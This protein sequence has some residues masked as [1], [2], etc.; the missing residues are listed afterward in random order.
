MLLSILWVSQTTTC[1][2]TPAFTH[3]VSLAPVLT[4]EWVIQNDELWIHLSKSTPGWAAIAWAQDMSNGDVLEIQKLPDDTSQ[5]NVTNCY[6]VGHKHPACTMTQQYTT[7]SFSS[8]DSNFSVIVK[9][10]L[11]AT[12]PTHGVS[13]QPGSNSLVWAYT[14]S[15]TI[16]FH[17]KTGQDGNRGQVDLDLS[18]GS[19]QKANGLKFGFIRHEYAQAII[20]T[21]PVDMLILL[22]RYFKGVPA[23]ADIHL[24]TFMFLFICSYVARQ[25]GQTNISPVNPDYGS[26]TAAY[27]DLHKEYN[28]ILFIFAALQLAGGT[29][30]K[31]SRPLKLMAIRRNLKSGHIVGGILTWITAKFF[32]FTGSLMYKYKFNN[33][34]LFT[35]ILT[36]TL[37]FVILLGYLEMRKRR[38]ESAPV[39][40]SGSGD[41]SAYSLANENLTTQQQEIINAIIKHRLTPAQLRSRFPDLTVFIFLNRVYNLTG[42]S[43]PG[44]PALF[45][46]ANW[47]EVS[48]FLFGVTGLTGD[49]AD[50]WKH[51]AAAFKTLQS[52]AIG[53]LYAPHVNDGDWPLRD[54]LD[55][56]RFVADE[57]RLAAVRRL[58]ATTS[59]FALRCD[60]VH[61]RND[62]LGTQWLGKHYVLSRAPHCKKVRLYTHC[63]SLAAEMQAYE[64]RLADLVLTRSSDSAAVSAL[65]PVR[66]DALPL[67]VKKYESTDGLSSALHSLAVGDSVK[68]EGPVGR[69]FL[70]DQTTGH[71]LLVAGGTGIL[72]FADLLSLLLRKAV[73]LALSRRGA[74]TEAVF[75]PQDYSALWRDCRFTL[76]CGFRTLED[77]VN[78][79]TVR[80]LVQVCRAA[81]LDLFRVVARVD[82]VDSQ[83]LG[84]DTT[85]RHFDAALLRRLFGSGEEVRETLVCGPGPMQVKL[86]KELKEFGVG[87]DRVTLV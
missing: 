29:F 14:K 42:F 83:T 63:A 65:F 4:M 15:N 85:D 18:S 13:I 23:W 62:L 31:I 1:Q 2:K 52:R 16:E 21:V 48:R 46:A 36:E 79:D 35:L 56:P 82:G 74:S 33:G 47:T 17:G 34:I 60:D 6:F 44:G 78:V 64:A 28:I 71:V 57:F 43:H 86:L 22:A 72:P 68:V 53:S 37:G 70:L 39:D 84:L 76:L 32:V 81:G 26:E 61:V 41:L 9:R 38:L 27:R 54:D 20:W 87:E 50:A 11:A 12:D 10:K 73:Y 24:Y 49:P 59:Q 69:G 45:R 30:F 3:S 80:R 51:S 19:A 77:F 7:V 67:V 58:S 25:T 40:W 66:L 75:P 55:K 8:T 5:L